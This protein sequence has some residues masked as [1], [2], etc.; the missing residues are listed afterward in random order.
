AISGKIEDGDLLVT[1]VGT[2]GVQY[3]VKPDDK[4][5][6]KDGNIIWIQNRGAMNGTYLYYC[7]DTN[8]VK[9][10]ISNMAGVGTVGTYTIDSAKQT[11]VFVPSLLEQKKIVAFL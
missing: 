10:Q 7:F 3:L 9:Q 5:Y 4:F 8:F 11:V 2:I 6:F 1:G